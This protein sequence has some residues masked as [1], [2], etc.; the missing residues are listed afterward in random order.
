MTKY[1]YTGGTSKTDTGFTANVVIQTKHQK[2]RCPSGLN[3]TSILEGK[4]EY[5]TELE[6]LAAAKEWAKRVSR[7]LEN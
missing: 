1:L 4:I 2:Y 5:Q 7:T 3:F 6:A